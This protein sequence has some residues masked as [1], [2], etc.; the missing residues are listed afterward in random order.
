[1]TGPP[2]GVPDSEAAPPIQRAKPN[3][4][5]VRLYDGTLVA[6]ISIELADRLIT[7]GAAETFR[8]GSR[9]YLRL[10][11]GVPFF[12]GAHGWDVI[13]SLRKWHGDKKAAQYVAHKDRQSERLK[14]SPASPLPER[15]RRE[16]N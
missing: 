15:Y 3:G 7:A 6:F 11:P 4:I 12:R 13:E 9:R 1:M 16:P 5:P 10:Q 2:G 8:R 14:Y